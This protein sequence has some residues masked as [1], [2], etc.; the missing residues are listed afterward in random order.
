ML[1]TTKWATCCVLGNIAALLGRLDLLNQLRGVGMQNVANHETTHY[2][3]GA[4]NF[5]SLGVLKI[6]Q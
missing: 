5:F 1:Y 2:I 3:V 6:G 4:Y